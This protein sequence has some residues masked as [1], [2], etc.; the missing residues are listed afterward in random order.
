M[1]STKCS[2]KLQHE[3]VL[4]GNQIYLLS[5]SKMDKELLTAAIHVNASLLLLTRGSEVNNWI[6]GSPLFR[7]QAKLCR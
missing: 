1:R 6:E 4:Q 5:A 3:D 7:N 2:S